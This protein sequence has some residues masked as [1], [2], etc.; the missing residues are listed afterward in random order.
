MEEQPEPLPVS[1][2][3]TQSQ[4]RIALVNDNKLMEEMLLR[5]LDAMA[6][7]P[8]V[9]DPRWVA[10]AR[11]QFEIAFMAFNRAIFRPQR[12]ELPPELEPELEPYLNRPDAVK[13]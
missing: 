6:G 2:Y 10:I 13:A 12:V 4:E 9:F 5:A 11:T 7:V 3:T 8:E 1:G